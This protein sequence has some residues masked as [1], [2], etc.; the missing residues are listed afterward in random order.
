MGVGQHLGERRHVAQAQIE[1]LS[2][3]GMNAVGGIA[4]EGQ[5]GRHIGARQMERQRVGPA[6]PH[7]TR[8]AQIVSETRR[9]RIGEGSIVHIEVI[10]G[11]LLGL[12]PHQGGA[13]ARHGQDGE[14][15]GGQEI[16]LRN[17]VMGALMLDRGDDAGLAVAPGH[18]LDARPLPQA[19]AP[20]VGGETDGG[21]H[22]RAGG[23]GGIDM[24]GF[25]FRSRDHRRGDQSQAGRGADHGLLGEADMAVLDQM[26]ERAPPEFAVVEMQEE[27]GGR[28]PVE[29]AHGAAVGHQNVVD[30]LG[31]GRQ[32]GPQAQRLQHPAGRE[33]HCRDPSVEPG[34]HHFRRIEPVHHDRV[35]T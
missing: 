34:F 16:F 15:T 7:R 12:R 2:G 3:N 32:M 9:H 14:R 4:D 5:P 29:R 8:R 24:P 6:R 18:G 21:T 31:V 25:E 1:P 28:P 30:G 23:E 17:A 33:S 20:P 35:D 13:V 19:R 27:G 22:S 10:G 26:A 11:H